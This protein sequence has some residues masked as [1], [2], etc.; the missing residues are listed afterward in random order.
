M[1]SNEFRMYDWQSKCIDKSFYYI[2][3]IVVGKLDRSYVRTMAGP[4]HQINPH[5]SSV[6]M[7]NFTT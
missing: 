3:H 5:V 7:Y 2:A 4:G 1:N 6:W